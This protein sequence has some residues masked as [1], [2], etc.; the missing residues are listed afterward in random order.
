MHDMDELS[1]RNRNEA[2]QETLTST[3]L[4]AHTEPVLDGTAGV[5]SNTFSH[6]FEVPLPYVPQLVGTGKLTP[7]RMGKMK[8]MQISSKKHQ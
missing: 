5:S 6:R 7:A 8:K 3:P 2:F 4:V 1:T